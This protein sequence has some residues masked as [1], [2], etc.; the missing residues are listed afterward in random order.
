MPVN[1]A[2]NCVGFLDCSTGLRT[3]NRIVMGVGVI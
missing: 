2:T 3:F 1:I